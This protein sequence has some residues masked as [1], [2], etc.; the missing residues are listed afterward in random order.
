MTTSD[1]NI[2][3]VPGNYICK[4]FNTIFPSKNINIVGLGNVYIDCLDGC[5]FCTEES[6]VNL[7]IQNLH[8]K[9]RGTAGQSKAI[10]MY[11]NNS[12]LDMT[13]IEI[14]GSY[15][16]CAIIAQF[17]DGGLLQLNNIRISAMSSIDAPIIRLQSD[18]TTVQMQNINVTDNI[19]QL[20][21][22]SS[23]ANKISSLEM[24]YCRVPRLNFTSN[25]VTITNS[26]LYEGII[27]IINNLNLCYNNFTDRLQLKD[28]SETS[29]INYTVINNCIGKNGFK[30]YNIGETN[31]FRYVMNNF[32]TGDFMIND[33]DADK[34]IASKIIRNNNYASNITNLL[35]EKD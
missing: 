23:L 31:D 17:G 14:S 9:L 11:N 4:S 22:F 19:S 25:A 5:P 20:I 6:S 29:I 3:I 18:T 10:Q 16:D 12:V 27:S 8:I 33:T 26:F 21:S 1:I 15:D 7:K 35:I 24:R 32:C 28:T 34:I 2:I 30:I 13:N